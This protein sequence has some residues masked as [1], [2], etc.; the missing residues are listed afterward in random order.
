[1]KKIFFFILIFSLFC[2]ANNFELSLL[3]KVQ[4]N[5]EVYNNTLYFGCENGDIYSVDINTK[6]VNW[7]INTGKKPGN[8]LRVV[9]NKLILYSENTLYD[10]SLEDGNLN[11]LY[12]LSSNINGMVVEDNVY[13]TTEDLVSV[14]SKEFSPI[15]TKQLTCVKTDPILDEYFIYFGC[16]DEI[17]SIDKINSDVHWRTKIGTPTY[18]K[19]GDL[20]VFIGTADNKIKTLEIVKGKET[21]NYKTGGWII[22]IEDNNGIV[23]FISNDYYVYAANADDGSII[24]EKKIGDMTDLEV[25]ENIILIGTK[26]NKIY[27]LNR[28]TGEEKFIIHTSDWPM[29]L[30]IHDNLVIYSTLDKKV[31]YSYIDN[32]CTFNYPSERSL[33]SS[34]EFKLNGTTYSINNSIN[35]VQIGIIKD[36]I[37]YYIDAQGRT[38][39]TAYVDPYEFTDG[40]LDIGCVL[41]PYSDRD[42]TIMQVIKTPQSTLI[43][44][45]KVTFPEQTDLQ[46]NIQIYALNKYNRTIKGLTALYDNK[47]YVAD[48]NGYISLFFSEPGLKLIEISRKGYKTQQIQIQAGDTPGADDYTL[49]YLAGIIILIIII[50]FLI[51]KIKQ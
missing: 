40:I 50:V 46:Q 7:K 51:K 29:N 17:Y 1:M 37:G 13:I 12:S 35:N 11:K 36:E 16:N 20:R 2:F 23:F 43:E 47:E 48:S 26:T 5:L 34:A 19:E 45:M 31:A 6:E 32:V 18:I 4:T 49:Y 33:V 9:D 38:N 21:W 42:P 28:E 25:N 10:Y 41:S 3:S 30:V 27:G 8:N 15:W 22:D 39:W 24:W 44:D 14:F